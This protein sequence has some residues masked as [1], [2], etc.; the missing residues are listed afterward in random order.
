MSGNAL[1]EAATVLNV[2]PDETIRLAFTQSLQNAGFRVREATNAATALTAASSRP[3]LIVL[4]SYLPDESGLEVCRRLKGDPATASIPVLVLCGGCQEGG[5]RIACFDAGAEACLSRPVSAEELVAQARTLL[6]L[7]RAERQLRE[8]VEEVERLL[9]VLPVSVWIAHDPAC[10]S[11]TGNRAAYEMLG[12]PPQTNVSVAAPADERPAVHHYRDGR[13]L[14]PEELPMQY[15]AA[16]G[17]EVRDVELDCVPPNGTTR[18]LYGSATPLRDASGA[19]RGCV[20]AFVDL[21]ERR[22]MEQA[23]RTSER[24][25][26]T[27]AGSAPVGIFETDAEGNCLYVNDRWCQMAGMTADM[28]RGKG[29]ATALHPEDR[30]RIFEEWYAAANGGQEFAGV[31]R[32]RTPA[33]EVTW[34]SGRAVTLRDERGKIGGYIGTITDISELKRTEEALHRASQRLTSLVDNTPLAVVEWD[35]DFRISRWSGAAERVFG[36]NAA[37][38]VGKRINDV[39]LVYDED[40]DTVRATM[41]RLLD[42]NNQYVASGNRNWTRDGR[43]I[44]C[45]WY[46]SILSDEVGRMEAVLSLVLDVTDRKRA[47]AELREADRRKDEFLATLAHELRNPLA[48]I[49]N[50]V[51]ILKT[52]GPPAHALVW[53]RGIIDRQV[54]QMARLLDDLLDVSRITR[55]HIPLRYEPSELTAIVQSAVET[56]RPHIAERNHELTITLPK[57]PIFIEGDRSR[58]AQVFLNL[59]TNAARY[60]N[61]GGHIRL[62]AERQ[63][64]EVVVSVKDSGIGIPT[65]QLTRVFEMFTQVNHDPDRSQEGLGIG[66]TLAKRLIELHGGSVEARS[67]GPGRGSEFIVRL[68]VVAE[69]SGRPASGAPEESP[70]AGSSLRVLIVDDNRISADSLSMV[71]RIEGYETRLAYDGVQG[72]ALAEEF[73]PHVVLLDLGLPKLSGYEVCREIRL[74]PWAKQTVIIAQTGW[75]QEEV[76]QRTREAGFDHHM[77]KPL[78]PPVLL[79]LLAALKPT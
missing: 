61:P 49:R 76:R 36:W 11:I 15:A 20:G 57:E 9:D 21:A 73:R 52:Q 59:L 5:W 78:D 30:D 51:Q 22:R 34:L 13:E 6:R 17:I 47:E 16:H 33:G 39:R 35:S 72:V 65:N 28:A 37:E 7:R 4:E 46:N 44:D 75:A 12:L 23:L 63:G 50:A 24:R 31:Y 56:S 8:R 41:A 66:L 10:H 71:L 68:P 32:F 74:R 27:L 62:T 77:V 60:T 19:V 45:E 70:V 38:M 3:D 29:W 14:S 18:H 25:F 58:L 55:G 2:N 64:N 54:D 48:P 43:V 40:W 67:E 79:K 42:G 53:A 69:P 1:G 26:K